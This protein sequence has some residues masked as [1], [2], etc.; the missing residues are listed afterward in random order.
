MLQGDSGNRTESGESANKAIE[1]GDT[2]DPMPY[3]LPDAYRMSGEVAEAK[4]DRTSAIRMYKRYVAIA[5][6]TAIDRSTIERKLASWGVRLE[7]EE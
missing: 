4:G 5:A 1:L 2:V 3:W 6:A 7:V